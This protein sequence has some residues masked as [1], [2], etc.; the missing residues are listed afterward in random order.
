MKVRLRR[1]HIPG[2]TQ[3]LCPSCGR[4]LPAWG[5]VCL[6]GW[7]I[8]PEPRDEPA[9]VDELARREGIFRLA[10]LSDLHIGAHG[11]TGISAQD[12]LYMILEACESLGVDHVLVTGDLTRVG[13]P[14]EM[15]AAEATLNAGGFPVARRTVIPGN[16]DLQESG[17]LSVYE[18]SFPERLPSVEE[19][20]PGVWLAAVDSNAVARRDRSL[21][22]ERFIAPVQGLVG[23]DSLDF[24]RRGLAGKEG[25]RILALHHHLARHAPEDLSSRWDVALGSRMGR[26]LLDPVLDAAAVLEVAREVGVDVILHGHKH[27]YGQTGYQVGGVPVFNAGST[28]LMARP[29]FR[30]FDF[31]DR[32][33]VAIFEAQLI[34]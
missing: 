16:H 11:P 28:T 1:Q 24:V 3:G 23:D 8:P 33:W 29:T 34:L 30:L 12:R 27:W 25:V 26:V 31:E 15:H 21:V 4:A 9:D 2:P 7:A 17:D 14:E 32:R 20:A 19:V 18:A 13:L 22:F 5:G 10:H 6:C